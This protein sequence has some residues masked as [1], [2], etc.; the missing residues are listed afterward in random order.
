MLEFAAVIA[1]A[2]LIV[3]LAFGLITKKIN[4]EVKIELKHVYSQTK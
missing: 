4:K 3:N 1:G 2:L